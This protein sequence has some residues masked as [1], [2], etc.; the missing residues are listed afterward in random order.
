MGES[1][2]IKQQQSLG[3]GGFVW[4]P[5]VILASCICVEGESIL[6]RPAANARALELG[7]GVGLVGLVAARR[8]YAVT[9]TDF[10]S[11]VPIMQENI[12]ENGLESTACAAPLV[13]GEESS[14]VVGTF[15][16]IVAADVV[17]SVYDY[18]ALVATLRSMS[19][20]G[21]T[22][23]LAYRLRFGE[24]DPV[25]GAFLAELGLDF[26]H[27]KLQW[28]DTSLYLPNPNVF[29]LRITRKEGS[30]SG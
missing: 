30:V 9:V 11:F 5:A 28:Q 6:P 7:A 10:P 29:I 27:E 14:S 4:D 15:E 18:A 21:T 23:L 25:I 26:E 17:C 8:G 13:W 16:L 12:A 2:K 24:D 1:L 19:S 3:R 22:I 20:A